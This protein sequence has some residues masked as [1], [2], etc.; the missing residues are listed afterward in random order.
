VEG[1]QAAELLAGF[2]QL[3][4]FADHANDVGLLLYAIRE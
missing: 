3:D 1:T 2:F 4:V